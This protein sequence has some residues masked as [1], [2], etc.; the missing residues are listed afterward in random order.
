M[1]SILRKGLFLVTF[2][3]AITAFPA[4]VKASD[5][6][7]DN[8]MPQVGI[9]E[10]LSDC[11]LSDKQIEVEDYLVPTQKG[12]YLDM[13]FANVQS[14]LYIRS[15]PTTDSEWVGKLYP[16]Y[17][18]KIIGPVGEWTQVQS[19]SVTGYVYSDYILIGKNAEQKAQE[20]VQNSG[21]QSP[22]EAFTYAESKEEE[23]ARLEKEASEA[24]AKAEE[25]ASAK[26]GTGQAIVDYACQFIGNPYVWGGTSLTNG[27]DCSG[28]VQSVFAH[29]GIS[30]PR[31]TWDMENVGTPVSYDQAIPGDIILYDGHVGIYM[32]DGQI[33]NAINSS[34]GIGILPAT[35]TSI[36]TVRRLI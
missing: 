19:G 20:M 16:D 35:Y 28:F 36:I 22:D 12:E 3:G 10:V 27:A 11:Y 24:A 34:R 14:F 17:A 26:A 1:D 21:T 2:T 32:G 7:T 5:T 15:E 18:A 23:A 31:T 6:V 13:A 4:T 8:I 29:F 30:L 25:E 33:V 9:E